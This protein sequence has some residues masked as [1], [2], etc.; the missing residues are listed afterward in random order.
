MLKKIR[1]YDLINI[2]KENELEKCYKAKDENNKLYAIKEINIQYKKFVD[3][4]IEILKKM[5]SK[6]SVEFIESIEEGDNIYIV[7]ELCDGDL[8]DLLDKYNGNLDITTIIEIIFQ[9]NEVLK[10]MVKNKIEHRD[11]KPENILIKY[12][13]NLNYIIVGDIGKILII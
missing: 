4:E 11:L 12:I 5:N 1:K 13:Y 2:I 6:Y 9:L 7:M 8:N 10:L 3:N